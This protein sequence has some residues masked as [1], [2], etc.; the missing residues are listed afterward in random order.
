MIKKWFALLTQRVMGDK[1][2]S[3]PT[4]L[5]VVVPATLLAVIADPAATGSNFFAWAAVVVSASVIAGVFFILYGRVVFSTV[6]RRYRLA[7]GL[8][9]Y[10]LI[11]ALRGGLIGLLSQWSG[12]LESINWQFRLGGGA[13]VGLVL[14][15]VAAAFVNDYFAF[16]A[17]LR[18]LMSSRKR[19]SELT[20]NAQSE[21]DSERALMLES[22]N[23]KLT[24]AVDEI[25]VQASPGQSVESYRT[26]VK[27]LLGVAETVV[28]PLSRQLLSG[29]QIPSTSTADK[30]L[31][32][33]TVQDLVR[34]STLAQPFRPLPITLIWAAIGA[35]TMS[36]L[37]PGFP[38]ILAYPLFVSLTGLFL[39]LGKKF[40]V[41]H[42]PRVL[43]T[44]RLVIIFCWFVIV[45]FVPAYLS[46]L[47]LAQTQRDGFSSLTATLLILDPVATFIMCCV[48]ASF[49]GLKSERA[50]ILAENNAINNDLRWKLA[51]IRG[52]LRAQRMELSRTVHG[53]VQ[54]VFIAVALK[55]QTAISKGSV[56]DVVLEEIKQ[57]L[58]AVANFT[59][60]A[61]EYP[62]LGQAVEELRSLWGESLVIS[63]NQDSE[64]EPVIATNDVLRATLID[65]MWE[66]VTNAVKHGFA[67]E[68]SISVRRVGQTIQMWVENDGTPVPENF[69]VGAGSELIAEVTVK[70]DLR[71]SGNK[72]VLLA[73][74]PIFAL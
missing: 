43:F 67:R 40:L 20:A 69:D 14:L 54:S 59:V 62:M 48:F 72:V 37:K 39:W 4:F 6:P 7:T 25:S 63:F 35:S 50:R 51:S 31:G 70:F 17:S 26:V 33:G 66:A 32:T 36:A 57:E 2:Y 11:G 44:T 56:S 53:D 30:G 71:N 29:A 41:P 28:R 8:F 49:A 18:E 34:A 27:N 22:I 52:L 65:V 68:V 38:E 15:P 73:D 12:V 5:V 46:W 13:L 21:L 42:L 47:P 60:G 1:A 19:L 9:G 74:I 10:A 23:S 61:K 24:A 58:A 16:Q 3:L 64:S 55:L 45:S